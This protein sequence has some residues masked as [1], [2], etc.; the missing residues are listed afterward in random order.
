MYYTNH[1]AADFDRLNRETRAWSATN[2]DRFNQS[3]RGNYT[4][5]HG[6]PSNPYLYCSN[7]KTGRYLG[8]GQYVED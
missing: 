2:I 6:N 4:Y 8:N 3:T 5:S 7:K 1:G